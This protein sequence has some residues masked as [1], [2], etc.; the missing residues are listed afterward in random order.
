MNRNEL[1]TQVSSS[2]GISKVNVNKTLDGV[3]NSITRSLKS[4]KDVRLVGFGTFVV[5]KRKEMKGRNPRT[6]KEIKI[7]A[8][9]RPKFRA[10]K[11]LIDAVN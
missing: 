1:I 7:K 10:G 9:H 2:T 3:I 4:G 11:A 6:G 8:S 5:M